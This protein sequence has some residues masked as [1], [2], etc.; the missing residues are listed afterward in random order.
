MRLVT[1]LVPS[2]SHI[3]LALTSP[4]EPPPVWFLTP[5]VPTGWIGPVN[6]PTDSEGVLQGVGESS[7]SC[8]KS[9]QHI[10]PFGTCSDRVHMCHWAVT[11][12]SYI[13]HLWSC[14][15]LDVEVYKCS[16]QSELIFRWRASEQ[17]LTYKVNFRA[18]THIL[19][20]SERVLCTR[21][22]FL[23]IT[24]HQSLFQWAC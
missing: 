20:N 23:K 22:Y 21:K 5:D 10:S 9:C 13:G 8:Q 12:P 11:C 19:L 1:V 16:Q 4:L 14:S 18:H 15:N 2:F 6:R 7:G 17:V 24:S 3:Q